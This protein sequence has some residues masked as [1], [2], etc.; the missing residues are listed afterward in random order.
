[1]VFSEMGIPSQYPIPSHTSTVFTSGIS[2]NHGDLNTSHL[3]QGI[4]ALIDLLSAKSR[5]LIAS[6]QDEQNL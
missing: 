1:M 2:R 6:C 4:L 5:L 3:L